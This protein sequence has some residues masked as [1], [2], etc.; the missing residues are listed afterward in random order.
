MQQLT[1]L[2]LFSV[3]SMNLLILFA[4]VSSW[5]AAGLTDAFCDHFSGWKSC[6]CLLPVLLVCSS[7]FVGDHPLVIDRPGYM[8]KVNI[9]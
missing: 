2:S 9:V 5:P 8:L 3:V 7:S 6:T 1:H 4:P